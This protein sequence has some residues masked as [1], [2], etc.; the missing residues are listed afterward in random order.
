MPSLKC[1][2]PEL[3]S[4]RGCEWLSFILLMI[5]ILA[6][7]L[8]NQDGG[9]GWETDCHPYDVRDVVVFSDA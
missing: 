5:D 4:R 9:E 1:A 2:V 3:D 7:P 8:A 6:R